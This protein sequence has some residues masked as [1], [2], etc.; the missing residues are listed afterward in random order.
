MRWRTTRDALHRFYGALDEARLAAVLIA[1]NGLCDSVGLV[2]SLAI[3]HLRDH[4]GQI[5]SAVAGRTR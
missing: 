1:P 2:Q 5:K 3:G 4:L